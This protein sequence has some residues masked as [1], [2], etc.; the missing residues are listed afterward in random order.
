[1]SM[2][3]I[4]HDLKVVRHMTDRIVIMEQ[5]RVVEEG[6]TDRIFS[7]PTHEVTRA[8]INGLAASKIAGIQE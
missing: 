8:L 6:T 5:G 7:Q 2:L 3:M 4:S 1:M